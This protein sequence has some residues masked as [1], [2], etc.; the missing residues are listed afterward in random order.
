MPYETH[1]Q[2][3][4]QRIDA[5]PTGAGWTAQNRDRGRQFAAASKRQPDLDISVDCVVSAAGLADPESRTIVT[6]HSQSTA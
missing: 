1:E 4:W 3:A 5:G 6:F 2:R